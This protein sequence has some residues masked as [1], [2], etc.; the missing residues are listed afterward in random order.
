MTAI[1]HTP[2]PK[3][4]RREWI[5]LALIV[6]P[7]LLYSMDL[8]VL[9][10]AIPSLSADLAPSATQLLWIVDIY[11]FMVAGWL[12]TMGTLG[13]RI[14][15][16]RI[17]MFGAA[18]F[19]AASVIAALAPTAEALIAARA[20]L[21]VAGATIAPSTLSLIRHMFQDE[22]Q[23]TVAIGA[24]GTGYA[25]GGLIGPVLGG[26]LLQWFPWGSVFLLAVPVMVL[27]LIAAPILLPEYKDPNAGRPDLLSAGLSLTAVLAMVYGLKHLAE[28]GPSALAGGAVLLGALLA[29][30][31]VRRQQR[32][33]D[34]LIDLALFRSKTFSTALTMNML[35]CL[36]IFGTFL[37]IAQYLQ[38]VL[39]LSPLEAG[40]WQLPSAAATTVGSMAS[41]WFVSRGR[42]S[43]V[44]AGGF[45]LMAAGFVLLS[46]APW[47]G[48]PMIVA[49]CVV[50]SIGLGPTFVLTSDL[51]LNAAP[52]ERAGGAGAIS[53]T[54]SEFGG[55]MGIALL[56]S[57][58]VAIY[59]ALAPASDHASLGLAVAEAERIGGQAGAAL[60]ADS[61]EAFVRAMQAVTVVCAAV[62]AGGAVA[63]LILLRD[64]RRG[65]T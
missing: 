40:L 33:T 23:R 19:G 38:L 25:A 31:F 2:P 52:P 49:G 10:L 9:N 24:W 51:I 39:G 27:V 41:P 34:P 53:E 21:G 15:R 11:G 28:H 63:A 29:L 37:F 62:S 65:G 48:L 60:L 16:R 46:L 44:V 26:V 8:T 5:G 36:V 58:G 55:V 13:D 6:L 22:G 45:A 61:R 42:P 4:T 47:G 32:L 50:M 12:I 20:L 14:G 57:L 35:G 1:A 43:R 30:G 54:G 7:C 3:A 18:A 56:G 17:L 64:A 59:Q